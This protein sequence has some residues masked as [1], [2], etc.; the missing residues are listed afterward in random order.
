[1]PLLTRAEIIR[2]IRIRKLLEQADSETGP[3]AAS[4][5][6]KALALAASYPAGRAIIFKGK[7]LLGDTPTM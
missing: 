3:A 1:M 7:P 5:R 2:A 4:Y 6:A